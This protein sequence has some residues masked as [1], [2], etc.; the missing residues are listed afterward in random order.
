MW[1]LISVILL[2]AELILLGSFVVGKFR[3][4]KLNETFVFLGLVFVINVS[5]YLVPYLYGIFVQGKEG[6]RVF[7]LMNLMERSVK[8]FLGSMSTGDVAEFTLKVPVF[9]LT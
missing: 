1:N 2:V 5:L 8:L 9:T 4:R 6:N 7:E 3:N